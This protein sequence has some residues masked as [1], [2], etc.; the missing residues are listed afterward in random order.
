MSFRSGTIRIPPE[1]ELAADVRAP[2]LGRI[3][4]DPQQDR[5]ARAALEA[6]AD[7]VAADMPWLAE[8]LREVLPDTASSVTRSGRPSNAYSIWP[9]P[10][11][12]V[13]PIM[14]RRHGK[15][16]V[17]SC[18][19]YCTRTRRPAEPSCAANR[20]SIVPAGGLLEEGIIAGAIHGRFSY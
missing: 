16:Y 17:S 5:H 13:S 3:E 18:C 14:R 2:G 4:L 8:W 6:Y 7:S 9:M 10:W 12:Q 20:Y 19:K 15:K 11:R 1:A